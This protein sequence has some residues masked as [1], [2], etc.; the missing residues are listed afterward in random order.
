MKIL[1][2]GNMGY[3]GPVVTRHLRRKF[4]GSYLVGLD[5]GL[6][7]HCNTAVNAHSEFGLNEQ[8][9]G[10][11]RGISDQIFDGV[12]AV[13]ELAAVS[14]D[15]MGD[16]FKDVTEEINCKAAISIAERAIVCGVK[17]VVFASSCSMYGAS[18]GGSKKEGD[19]L[20]PL[21]NYAKSKVE[22]ELGLAKL[23]LG[24]A[25]ITALRFSTACGMS[26]RLRLD[27][28]L[29]DFVACAVA[30]KEITVLSDGTPW[31][32]LI[33]V[34]DM[35]RAIEW[36]I[37]R[38]PSGIGQYLA[39]NVGSENWN[40]QVKDLAHAVA[41]AV[42]GTKVNI[43]QLAPPDKRSY[44]VNFELFKKIAPDHQPLITLEQAIEGLK[45]GLKQIGFN[46]TNFR[47][48]QYMRLK[49]LENQ[50]EGKML[51][52]KLYWV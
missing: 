48:S 17:R 38:D 2:T 30:M 25:V 47:T 14:N 23:N 46:D 24:E 31:R 44:K 20:N 26:N 34:R 51:N 42:P 10:D 52:E 45:N 50:I 40:Y 22:A 49:V 19:L 3:V 13:V 9:F 41:K 21:T 18:S 1:I 33:E 6:F 37:T 5:S 35:A 39:V 8:H 32:P 16:K 36:A 12:D 4:P 29:N 27:L 43:N 7:A 11:V 28:V 15:P